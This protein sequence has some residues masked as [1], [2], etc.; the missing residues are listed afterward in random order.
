M[1]TFTFEKST[2]DASGFG[3]SIDARTL[4]SHLTGK[5]PTYINSVHMP[6]FFGSVNAELPC[7]IYID[8]NYLNELVFV[9]VKSEKDSSRLQ[10]LLGSLYQNPKQITIVVDD[11]Y[12]NKVRSKDYIIW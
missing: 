11:A 6:G 3:V 5:D 9:R 8:Y 1:N 4:F 2:Y 12:W 7:G 10:D